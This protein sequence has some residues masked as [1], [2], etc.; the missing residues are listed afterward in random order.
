MGAPGHAT[1]NCP[2]LKH[3]IQDLIDHKYLILNPGPP[4]VIC[5]DDI[6][7]HNSLSDSFSSGVIIGALLDEVPSGPFA[8]PLANE[9]NITNWM[10]LPVYALS[11]S[12]NE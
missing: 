9:E 4:Q 12:N 10:T 11:L 3:R 2:R 8:R 7:V 1:N 5:L 6:N